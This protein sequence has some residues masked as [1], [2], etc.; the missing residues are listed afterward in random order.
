MTEDRTLYLYADSVDEREAW[1]RT[2]DRVFRSFKAKELQAEN[3]L[4][5][6]R[7]KSS[8]RRRRSKRGT[9]DGSEKQTA[10]EQESR[11]L[12]E[13]LEGKKRDSKSLTE[14]EEEAS[15]TDEVL[16]KRQEGAGGEAKAEAEAAAEE[17]EEEEELEDDDKLAPKQQELGWEWEIDQNEIEVMEAIGSGAFGA[18]YRG[19][20]WGSDVAVKTLH[21][22]Q[23]TEDNTPIIDS[24]KEES[25]LLA[26]LRHPNVVL[27]I[28]ACTKLPNI[29]IVTEWCA[30][31][32]LY[33]LLHEETVPVSCKCH[34]VDLWR[35]RGAVS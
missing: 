25:E 10:T 7:K 12:Q 15:A 24:L 16:R 1:V 26:R 13:E 2:I 27:Y 32:S 9:S 33:D 3:G 23:Q 11:T 6:Q 34:D 21:A 29:C 30:R 17:E 5:S 14:K 31:G 22:A 18:V 20:L 4:K 35:S 19:R 28:G 8:S